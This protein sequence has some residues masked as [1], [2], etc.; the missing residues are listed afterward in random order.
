MAATIMEIARRLNISHTTVSRVLN[1][2]ANVF[3]SNETRERVLRAATEMG[4][5]PNLAARSLREAR[6]SVIAVFGSAVAG[7]WGGI[8]PEIVRG[9]SGVL[10]DRHYGLFFALSEPTDE[11]EHAV[12]S[13]RFDG[14][15]VLQ[16]PS[17][18]TLRRLT[19]GGA[20]LV[21]VN[22]QIEGC[23]AVLSDDLSGTRLALEH[24][25]ELGHRK[26]AYA[27]V[28]SWHLSH[29][30]VTE[31]HDAY[32][33][34][35]QDKGAHPLT[36][37]ERLLPDGP[38]EQFLADARAEG[39]TAVLSYDHVVATRIVAAASKLGLRIPDD[40]SMVCFNDEFP[41]QDLYPPVTV[42]APEGEVMGKRGGELLLEQLLSPGRKTVTLRLPARLIVR[43][44]TAPL[45]AA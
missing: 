45:R 41:V 14:A 28:T 42:V 17:P 18:V 31:R 4:Y 3:V 5:R 27:G 44:S 1:Q 6:T 2:K 19:R 32:V 29:Y 39:A 12:S 25:W 11:E 26:I 34:F 37:H 20:P 36:G 24:L 40:F 8:T 38:L 7:L 43:Q 35:L 16:S 23:S 15:I 22:E 13:W 33:A 30:S 10:R 21:C 9:L